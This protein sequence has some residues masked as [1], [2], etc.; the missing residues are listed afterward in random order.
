MERKVVEAEVK[1]NEAKKAIAKIPETETD[2]PTAIVQRAIRD[3]FDRKDTQR[4]TEAAE[5]KQTTL[6]TGASE[7]P[8]YFTDSLSK[9]DKSKRKLVAQ[10]MGIVSRHTDEATL[11]KIKAELEKEFK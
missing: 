9:L 3:H 2:S 5:V 6:I 10:V 1:K 4:K 11:N 8:K 7:K